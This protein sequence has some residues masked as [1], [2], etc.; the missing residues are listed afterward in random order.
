MAFTATLKL[1]FG[2]HVLMS[3]AATLLAL[4]PLTAPKRPPAYNVLW[5]GDTASA[6]TVASPDPTV[7]DSLHD[8]GTPVAAS[9]ATKLTTGRSLLPAAAPGGLTDEKVPPAK[10][11]PPA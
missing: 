2:A 6:R 1:D 4:T 11:T 3:I 8:V 9:S 10:T 5:S 7:N